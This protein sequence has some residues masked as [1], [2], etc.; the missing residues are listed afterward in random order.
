MYVLGKAKSRVYVGRL[1]TGVSGK[2]GPV[3]RPI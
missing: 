1:E 3:L 2:A